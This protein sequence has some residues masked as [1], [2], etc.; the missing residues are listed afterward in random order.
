M[1]L[2]HS[3][4]VCVHTSHEPTGPSESDSQTTP[5]SMGTDNTSG[6]ALGPG[7]NRATLTDALGK[8]MCEFYICTQAH[9]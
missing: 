5:I 8:T 9:A 3:Q 1:N 2:L 4:Y 7:G 6:S